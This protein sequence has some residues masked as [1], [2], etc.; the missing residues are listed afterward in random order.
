MGEPLHSPDPT[1]TVVKTFTEMYGYE[2]AVSPVAS[3]AVALRSHEAEDVGFYDINGASGL[4]EGVVLT[5]SP[6]EGDAP[7]YLAVSLD[8]KT[9]VTGN[10]ISKNVTIID[11]ETRTVE[12]YVNTGERVQHVA[13]TPDGQT[14]LSANMSSN[15]TSC[16]FPVR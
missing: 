16:P 8:G 10:T 15:L 14:A 5:G 9:A 1:R 6:P 11:L 3:R 12:A 2:A 13:I 7:R 4:V